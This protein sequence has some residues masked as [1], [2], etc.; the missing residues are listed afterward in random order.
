[1]SFFVTP[2]ADGAFDLTVPGYTVFVLLFVALLL[3][4]AAFFNSKKKISVKQLVFSSMAVAL[5]LVTSMIK[6]FKLPM[7]GSVT[8]LSMLFIV[9]IGYW[10]GLGAG[11]TAAIA[12]GI[13]QL[14]IDPYI[15]SFPQMMVDYLLAFGALGLS[16]LFCNKKNG[17]VKGYIVGVLGRYF[18]A[19]L[20]GWIFFGM[21]APEEFPNA[22]VY[23]LAYNGSYIGAEALITL[24]VISLPPVAKALNA[25]KKQALS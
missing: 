11:L 4:G 23:S 19:F 17:L 1:M 12:Y 18:F 9:L 2:N 13:L 21:Y 20:S 24:I 25:V 7:G 22:V 5:A 8:L 10:Y 16:G 3:A 14:I 6:L 15:L